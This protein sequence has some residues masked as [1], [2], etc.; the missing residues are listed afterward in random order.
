MVQACTQCDEVQVRERFQLPHNGFAVVIHESTIIG[1]EV[2]IY[3]GVTI[4]RTDLYHLW[5]ETSRAG[6]V[7]VG[8]KFVIGSGAKLLFKSAET[9]T[10][11]DDSFIGANGVV[12]GSIPP[13]E[14]GAGMSA[15]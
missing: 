5:A 15:R 12:A 1:N 2:R 9:L 13:R 11:G 3:P 14:V 10:L 8:D 4:G 6:H 7:V